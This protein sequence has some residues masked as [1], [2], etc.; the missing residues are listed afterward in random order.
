MSE[1]DNQFTLQIPVVNSSR[2]VA[3][4][5]CWIPPGWFRIGE[6]GT[7]SEEEPPTWVRIE[8]GFW[9]G[10]YPVTRVQYDAIVGARVLAEEE[11]LPQTRISWIQAVEF[12]DNLNRSCQ[13]ELK[14]GNLK[15][16]LPTEVE[17]E[18]ACRAGT[19]TEYV[20]GDGIGALRERQLL[21]GIEQSHE[22]V[23]FDENRGYMFRRVDTSLA[24][25]FG[26][27]EVHGTV[28]ELCQDRFDSQAYRRFLSGLTAAEAWE[29]SE[30]L[31]DRSGVFEMRAA[32]GGS[33]SVDA[34]NCRAAYRYFFL[35]DVSGRSFGL[36][37]CL[38]GRAGSQAGGVPR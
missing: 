22:M 15:A 30:L 21:H 2:T 5:F 16:R 3:M 27:H 12:L 1:V 4:E 31:G 26:L 29:L 13:D 17:W 33:R 10:K 34:V 14:Q 32:R 6:R 36:R 25:P 9:M 35:A 20:F 23:C 8:S 18:Y 19:D 37:A 38:A 7:S 11:L 28:W 24:N